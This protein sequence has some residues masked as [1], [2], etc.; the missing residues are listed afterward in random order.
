MLDKKQIH[1]VVL[2]ELN[3]RISALNAA[4]NDALDATANET[5]STAG[6]KHETGRAMAQLE[7]EKLGSQISEGHKLKE[8]LSRIDPAM[9]SVSVS[10]GSLV[11]TD[12][13]TFYISIGIGQ[14]K[15]GDQEIFCMTP[16]APLCKEMLGKKAGE[17]ITWQGKKVQILKIA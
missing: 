15:I 6:D 5:K 11:T 14:M 7:Q 17:S 2:N 1:E 3:I 16:L 10:S 8:I 4:L 9:K 13:G 12:T